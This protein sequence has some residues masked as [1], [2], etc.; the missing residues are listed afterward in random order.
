MVQQ[1]SLTLFVDIDASSPDGTSQSTTRELLPTLLAAT[2]IT[3]YPSTHTTAASSTT[4][5]ALVPLESIGHP[6]CP[7]LEHLLVALKNTHCLLTQ[8]D[9]LALQSAELYTLSK[10]YSVTDLVECSSEL[11][12]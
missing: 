10:H 12:M 2:S 9:D 5:C 8:R 4:S 7:R 3:T 1:C 11:F 6:G